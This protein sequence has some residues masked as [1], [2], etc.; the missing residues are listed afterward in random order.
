MCGRVN[1]PK[2]SFAL[3]TYDTDSKPSKTY[4]CLI[5][6]EVP[7][8]RMLA[9]DINCSATSDNKIASGIDA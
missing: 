2:A 6:K 9:S 3:L 7:L 1:K 5:G 4:S 8:Y